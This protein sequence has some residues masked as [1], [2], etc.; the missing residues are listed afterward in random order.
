MYTAVGTLRLG[1]LT[2]FLS[3][4]VVGGF[5]SGAAVIIGLC[6]ARFR[7]MVMVARSGVGV[8]EAGIKGGGVTRG[9]RLIRRAAG[10]DWLYC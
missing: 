1:F 7:V 6:Q 2:N 5:T 9:I 8:V 4:S 3:H 10:D